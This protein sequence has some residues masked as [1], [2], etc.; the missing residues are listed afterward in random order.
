MRFHEV[1]IPYASA[2]IWAKERSVKHQC[3]SVDAKATLPFSGLRRNSG[4]GLI[5]LP[6]GENSRKDDKSKLPNERVN[7]FDGVLNLVVCVRGLDAQLK[8]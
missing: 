5:P 6:A 8:N 2:Y 3:M 1:N 4:S 7:L